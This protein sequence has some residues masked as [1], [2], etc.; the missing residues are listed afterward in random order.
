MRGKAEF[1]RIY[2]LLDRITP[3]CAGKSAGIGYL[4]GIHEDH[5]RVCGEKCFPLSDQQRFEGSPPRVRGKG[6]RLFYHFWCFGDHPRVCGEKLQEVQNDCKRGGSPP[7]VRGKDC[8]GCGKGGSVRITP[9][10][11]G[12]S[13]STD[14]LAAAAGDHPR[15][16][17]EKT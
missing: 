2:E 3:A 11:A 9:A 14:I 10:C 15:V 16:C 8:F 5:P 4:L 17:G 6:Y 1:E 13:L 7:R 12:K